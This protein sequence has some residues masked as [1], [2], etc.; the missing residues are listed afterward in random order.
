MTTDL[1]TWAQRALTE[2]IPLDVLADA[3]PY[4]G[5]GADEATHVI[6]H[7]ADAGWVI[8]P[9]PGGGHR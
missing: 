9:S 2:D 8:V 4:S 1:V 3:L 5:A 6:T 7:L